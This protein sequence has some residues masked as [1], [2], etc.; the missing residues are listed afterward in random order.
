MADKPNL[1]RQ[2]PET[3]EAVQ[4]I[5]FES[6]DLGREEDQAVAVDVGSES[7]SVKLCPMKSFQ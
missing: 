4:R 7:L 1:R 2:K 3:D 5:E 6:A